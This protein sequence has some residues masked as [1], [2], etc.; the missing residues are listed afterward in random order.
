M[1]DT[2]ARPRL[3]VLWRRVALVALSL[4]AVVQSS[5]VRGAQGGQTN[6]PFPRAARR[7][8]AHGR[9]AEAEALAKARPANDPAAA[10]V[11]GRLAINRGAYED[12][13]KILEPAAAA[14]P[15]SDAA[16]ELGLLSQR[17]GRNQQ[18]TRLLTALSRQV[19]PSADLETLFRAGRAAHALA[20][21]HDA[22]AYFKAAAERGVDPAVQTEYGSMFLD[23][24]YAADALKAFQ[25]A[26]AADAQWAPGYAGVARTLADENP[27]AAAEAANKALAIDPTLADA[28][29]TLAQ[30]DLDSARYDAA[31]E[32]IDKVL[33]VNERDLDARS[34]L[35]AIAYVRTGREAFDI[36]AKKVL[37]VNP[38]FGEVY[39]VAA[40]LAARNYRFDEAVALSREAVALDPSNT[41]A[42][43]DLGLQLMRTGDEGAA[44]P[45]LDRAFSA[46]GFDKITKNLLDLLDSLNKFDVVQDADVTF[47]FSPEETA[48]MREYAI[49]LAQDALKKLSAKYQFTPKGPILVEIFPHH[50]DFAVRNLGL[51][52]L[53]GALGAC[54]GRVVS[55]DS[56]KAREPGTFS[57]QE[58]LWHELTHVITLQMSKQRVPRW[59]TEGVSVYE[60]GQARPEWGREMEVPFAIAMEQG[61]VLKLKDLN[62][63]FT[64]AE[65]IALAYFEASL[66]VDHIVKSKGEAALRQ[67]LLT[68]GDGTEGDAAIQKG[69][70]ITID[71]LQ[72]T[73]DASL[74]ARFSSIR[75]A[76]RD[77][78]QGRERDVNALRLAAG[79]MPG[80]YRAQMAYGL[81]LAEQGDKAAFEPLEKAAALI[82]VAIG[83]E[84][85]HAVMARL[86]EK[87]GDTTRAIAE[88]RLFLAN[89]HTDVA[90]ARQLA[91]LAEK[92]GDEEASTLARERVV[93]LD[94]FDAESHTG[95]GRIALKRKDPTL[96]LREFKA[97]LVTGA[98]DKASAHCDLADAYLLAAKPAEA[99][100]EA[101]AAL[102]IA[103]SFERAQDLLLKSVEG[104]SGQ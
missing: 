9:P 7:A 32:R 52:G 87:L 41:R 47:K 54:F 83:E 59:L 57:W 90:A 77:Q 43:A 70:G 17:L 20:L 28:H 37:A 29:L 42:Y 2:V 8:L 100:R 62:S 51:P 92:A 1:N 16:L 97:A 64:K 98:A 19:G 81:A 12:A 68:Y 91:T 84:S 56:P 34:L 21:P 103:P 99:K 23:I 60:E 38:T 11:L 48:V 18:A 24:F 72:T 15:R 10:A 101:L 76:L 95:L 4:V 55:I 25:A 31:R 46:N 94:P 3:A 63:G 30:M 6:E 73:F 61:K 69:L 13:L 78:P 89:D 53:I 50:D 27:T 36:E 44:R 26:V 71:Q 75:A 35:A 40:D 22:D 85:P 88:Y 65:T 5:S 58:T 93:A 86:A 45:A 33:A 80:S 96:A 39:R 67:L 82:P 104:K 14:D 74:D 79:T 102:E 49:P 66:L